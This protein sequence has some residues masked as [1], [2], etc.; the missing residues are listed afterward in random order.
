MLITRHGKPSSILIGSAEE[1]DRF[2]YRLEHDE[3]FLKR[4]A[5]SREQARSG[6][7]MRLEKLADR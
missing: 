1:D 5:E 6:R 7:F 3:Q 4:M 2:Y